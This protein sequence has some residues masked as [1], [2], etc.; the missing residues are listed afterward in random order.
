MEL[1]AQYQRTKSGCMMKRAQKEKEIAEELNRYGKSIGVDVDYNAKIIH[2]KVDNLKSK[3]KDLYRKFQVSTATGSSASND[4]DF[5]AACTSW[6]NF[7]TWHRLFEKVPGFGPLQTVSSISVVD[8][9]SSV[10]SQVTVAESDQ[11]SAGSQEMQTSP[12][13]VAVSVA[14]S[15]STPHPPHSPLRLT[16]DD[17][18]NDIVGDT[19]S[20]ESQ[21]MTS[22]VA[23]FHPTP[24]ST[25]TTT[26]KPGQHARSR[27]VEDDA[28]E[29]STPT[30][31]PKKKKKK[32]SL[33][34][35]ADATT[36]E[37]VG[38]RMVEK[39]SESQARLQENQ[40][41]FIAGIVRENREHTQA[42]VQSQMVFL[43]KLFDEDK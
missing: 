3:A 7:K 26:Y 43:K 34:R 31:E 11:S 4:V 42:L 21:T 38:L 28:D 24:V 36:M 41:R 40:Q 8:H 37:D 39:L 12:G 18:D 25:P 23:N 6:A 15:H 22:S 20:M 16:G 13:E 2:N 27:V 29:S 17:S 1:W 33:P 10:S 35:S 19:M 14:V 32:R 30:D 5:A 9:Q